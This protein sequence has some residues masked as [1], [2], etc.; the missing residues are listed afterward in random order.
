MQ[1]WQFCAASVKWQDGQWQPLTP[2]DV[3]TTNSTIT[4]TTRAGKESTMDLF[5]AAAAVVATEV[6]AVVVV[7]AAAATVVV[8]VVVVVGGGGEAAAAAAE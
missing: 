5:R 3:R 6:V 2:C 8:V 4:A 1:H 7:V